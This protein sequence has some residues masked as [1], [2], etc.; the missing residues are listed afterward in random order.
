MDVRI[1]QQDC[2]AFLRSLPDESVDLVITDPAYSGMNQ[3]LRL[4]RGRIIGQYADA[5]GKGAKWFSEFHDDP[6]NYRMF[7]RECHR[8]LRNNRHVYIMFD[9]FSLLS[10]GAVVREVFDVK[11]VIVWDKKT[12]GLG[13]Y[14]RRRHEFILFASKGKRPVKQRDIPDVWMFQRIHNMAYPTQKP[15]ELFEQM[16]KAST[17]PGF[18]V[19]DPFVGSGS[20]AIAALKHECSFWGCDIAEKAVQLATKR[21]NFFLEWKYDNLKPVMPYD[22]EVAPHRYATLE[23]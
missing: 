5:G 15:V 16:V 3:H 13:H 12:I 8:V 6:G 20:S 10:L 7:L 23:Y 9:T 1:E 2:I 21:V 11:G 4:G 17:E 19:C 14:F 22:E 18:V